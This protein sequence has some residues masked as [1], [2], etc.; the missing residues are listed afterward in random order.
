MLSN[1]RSIR[2]G[3]TD[4][5]RRS[6]ESG[7]SFVPEQRKEGFPMCSRYHIAEDDLP[8]ELEKIMDELNRKKTPEGMKTSGEIFPSDIVPV[9]ANSRRQE[10]QPFAMRWGYSYPN[11][12]PIINARSETAAVKP[13]FRDGMNQRRCLIPATDYYEWEKRDGRKIKYAIRPECSSMLYLAGIYHLEKH[14][15][16]MVPAFAVLTR[17]AAPGISFIHERMPVILPEEA[18]TDWLNI[19]MDATKVIQSAMVN[20]EYQPA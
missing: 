13:M 8:E 15:E 11:G 14:G 10:I 12:R 20:M 3:K 1:C 6:G 7:A 16:V 4:D 17:E 9:L 5:L 19:R 18:V 2:A